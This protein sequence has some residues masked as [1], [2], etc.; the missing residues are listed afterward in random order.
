MKQLVFLV[1]ILLFNYSIYSQ[2]PDV[3]NPEMWV[4]NGTVRA[5]AVDG[6]YTY[7]GGD[8]TSVG[9]ILSFG[10]KLTVSN[11]SPDLTFPKVNQHIYTTIS[12]GS[13]GWYIGGQFT[14]LVIILE[15]TLHIYFLMEQLTLLG[16]LM[17]TALLTQ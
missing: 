14:K 6:N 16:I 13:G 11:D 9:P 1:V 17:L 8:F 10:A 2:E 3:P 15:T 7:I 4:T 12:D 5:I